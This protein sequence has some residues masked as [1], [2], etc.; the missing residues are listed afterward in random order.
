MTTNDRRDFIKLAGL[1]SASLLFPFSFNFLFYSDSKL[2]PPRLNKG[3]LIGIVSPAGPTFRK[4][5]LSKVESKIAAMGLRVKF[6]KHILSKHGYLA[7][8]DDE[9]VSDI[10]DMFENNSIKAIMAMRGGGVR[11]I[12]YYPQLR[13]YVL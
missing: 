2:F 7:G 5:D 6:G 10:H 1:S 9:R 3:D 11:V 8:T 4:S 12:L 13:P